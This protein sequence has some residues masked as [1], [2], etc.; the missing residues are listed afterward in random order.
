ML[1]PKTVKDVV[2]EEKND[3]F[4][5]MTL[6]C[7]K[8]EEEIEIFDAELIKTHQQVHLVGYASENINGRL[9]THRLSVGEGTR[10]CFF[11]K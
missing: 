3:F 4:T 2:A 6:A 9:E 5:A 7:N 8:T 10:V 1:N 11:V